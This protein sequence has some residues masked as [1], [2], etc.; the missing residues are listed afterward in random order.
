MFKHLW[1]AYKWKYFWVL[2]FSVEVIELEF[3]W[4]LTTSAAAVVAVYYPTLMV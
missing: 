3:L 4:D 2:R 1:C